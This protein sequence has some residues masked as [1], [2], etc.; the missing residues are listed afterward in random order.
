MAT[1]TTLSAKSLLDSLH[2]AST[3]AELEEISRQL[4]EL[5]SSQPAADDDDES[6][7][8]LQRRRIKTEE[9][10][11]IGPLPAVKDPAR[12]A[13]CKFDLQLFATTYCRRSLLRDG[14]YLGFAP[15]QVEMLNAFQSAILNGGKE[16]RAVRRG[17]LKSTL[18]RIATAWAVL[19]GHR[20]FPVLVGATDDK[21]EEHRDNTLD[22]FKA[23]KEMKEDFPELIPLMMKRTN[24]KRQLR[25]NGEILDVSAKDARGCILFAEIPG[26]E[27]SGAR[28]A[29][30]SVQSTD[31]SGLSFVDDTGETIRPDLLVFDDVQTPQS[32][33]SSMLTSRRENTICTTFMGLAA[34]GATIACIMVCTVREPDDLTMR[35]C[36]RKKHPDW[37][38]KT[39]PVL[40]SEPDGDVAKQHWAAY[41]ELLREGDTPEEGFAIATAYYIEHRAEMDAGGI[42][43]WELDKEDGYVSAL[44]WCMTKSILQPDYFRCELQQ[45]G[46]APQT[47]AQ[48]VAEDLIKRLSGVTRGIVPARASYLSAFV[49]SSDHVLWWM[50]IGWMKDCTSWIVDYGTW[51][52]QGR[53][54]FYKPTLQRTIQS[55]LPGASW[56]EAFVHAHNELDEYLL[57]REW[58]VEGGCTRPIDLVLKDCSDGGQKRRIEPQILASPYKLRLRQSQ[59]IPVKPGGKPVHKYGD[60]KRDRENGSDWVERRGWSPVG[61]QYATNVWKGF[62]IRRLRTVA[63]APSAMMLPGEDETS[64]MLLAEHFTSEKAVLVARNGIPDVAYEL[65]PGRDNDWFDC[66]VGNGVAASMLGCSLPGEAVTKTERRK[67]VI[68]QNRRR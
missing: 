20:K 68:P 13:K 10:Q 50:V 30:Y 52:D 25:L 1:L 47:T 44:Q 43:A 49:D 37:N 6:L 67:V 17:G 15:Y 39:F 24:P 31:I 34:L 32:A 29:P 56:E 59:S 21:S 46:A 11:E 57:G 66:L 9:D 5:E 7:T 55:A 28:I 62:A 19:Y 35:F 61:V 45:K 51:P 63:G 54:V 41:G 38:G 36:D 2:S 64:L 33:L 22:T 42:V 23:G 12:R 4:A 27:S 53:D 18:A 16:A 58:P 8:D 14:D 26:I 48:L 65:R 60:S 40:L 3:M